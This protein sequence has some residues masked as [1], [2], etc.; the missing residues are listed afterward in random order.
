LGSEEDLIHT[1]IATEAPTLPDESPVRSEAPTQ[2]PTEA[3]GRVQTAFPS[4]LITL[5]SDRRFQRG[6]LAVIILILIVVGALA[7]RGVLVSLA[8]RISNTTLAGTALDGAALLGE[9]VDKTLRKE[10]LSALEKPDE[11]RALHLSKLYADRSSADPTLSGELQSRAREA[12]AAG[13]TK[14]TLRYVRVL[15]VVDPDGAS[16]LA[17]EFNDVGVAALLQMPPQESIAQ[18]YLDAVHLIDETLDIERSQEA[19]SVSLYNQAQLLEASDPAAAAAVYRE[20][21][22]LDSNNLEAYYALSSLLLVE[23]AT[24][25]AALDEAV[26]IAQSGHAH[27]EERFCQGTQAQTDQDP[28]LQSWLCFLL[29]T[30]EAGARL[31]RDDDPALIMPLVERAIRLAEANDQFGPDRYTAEAYYYL[32]RL[33]EPDTETVVLCN[34]IKN[35]DRDL[36]RHRAWALY[37]NEQLGDRRCLPG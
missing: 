12:A 26:E 21:I 10:I 5:T 11:M 9:D 6:L 20:A 30:T 15:V 2:P 16:A 1:V 23:F 13:Q 37:A 28:A 31:E 27:I 7:L 35:H 8:L 34:I 18:V 24:D 4:T 3:A 14:V 29:M 33:T 25:P 32:A 22:R 36:D 17:G 19:Q